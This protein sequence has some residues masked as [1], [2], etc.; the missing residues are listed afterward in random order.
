M[1]TATW[2]GSTMTQKDMM[3]KDTVLVLDNDDNVIGSESKRGSHEFTGKQPRGVLHRAFSVFMFDESTG[4]L[5]LQQRASTKITFPNVWTNTCCSH[6]LHGMVP[7]EVDTPADVAAGTVLGA[8]NAAVRKLFH[9]LGIPAKELPIA[10]FKFLTRLHYWAADTVT[11]G[12]KSPWGEHEI[13]YVLFLTI[14][15]K[16]VLTVNPH[17][18]E[19]DAVKWVTKAKLL[20]MMADQKLL[21]SPWFRLIAHRWMLNKG[22]WWE[23][24][25]QTMTTDKH[26]DY[27]GIQRFDPPQ[28]HLGGGGDA[29]RMFEDDIVG[30]QSKKQGGYGK[31]KVHTESKV[32]QLTHLDEVFS[33]FTF[34]YVKPL[35]SNLDTEYIKKTFGKEDLAFCDEILVKVSRSFAAVIRQLPST[36]LVDIMIF[37]LV[38]R[39]LDTVEDDMTA[40]DSNETKIKEVKAFR[41]NALGNPDWTMDGVGEADEKRLLQEFPKCHRVYAAL[42]PKSREII[43]DITQ[44]MADG[45]AEFVGKDLGQGTKDVSE[46]NRYCHFVAGLVGEG[47]SR[48]FSQSGLEDES[49]GKEVRLSDQMGLFLQ[50]TNIIRDYL[51]DYVDG[52]AFWPQTVWKMYSKTGDLG[53]FAKQ[54]DP[55]ARVKSLECL[56]E[57]VTDALELAP[58]CL[59]YM[60]KLKCAEVF[61]FCAIPQVMAIATLDKCFANPNVFTGVVKIRKGT[62]CKLILLTNNLDEVHE[63]FY[64][65]ASSIMMTAKKHK[66]AGVVDPSFDRTMKA[67]QVI[68]DWTKAA[69]DRQTRARRVPLIVSGGLLAAAGAL[70]MGSSSSVVRSDMKGT[71][72]AALAGTAGLV[73]TFGF[74]ALRSSSTLTTA[75]DII[76]KSA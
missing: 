42:N 66:A 36:M 51:E 67:C 26:C 39:A 27:T 43:D 71:L 22:G 15:N 20:E 60:S 45:M 33:A 9:E 40:F 4:E 13:D 62:S 5:L 72:G 12:T 19:V 48:L 61:R 59:T 30:D 18:D 54:S 44:R 65:F 25:K 17:P 38:L 14:P 2:D 1:A 68:L 34:L 73:Y 76:Q 46:Y 6:P 50:K 47:L 3:E 16:S 52:R 75:S 69:Y 24:L 41:K 29:G 31:L 21:F 7:P 53:Y 56:N 49:F 63:T 35:K 10:N 28:E 55:D 32:K 8:K 64:V 37:Y 23:D 70:V 58:D 57:L 74:D 11:H